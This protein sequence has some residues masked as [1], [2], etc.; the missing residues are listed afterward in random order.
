MPA[1]A[2]G[3][4]IGSRPR[5]N[6]SLLG[7]Q[8][9]ELAMEVRPTLHVV[10]S[11]VDHE[12]LGPQVDERLDQR[13]KGLLVDLLQV[14]AVAVVGEAGVDGDQRLVRLAV[15]HPRQIM[16]VDHVAEHVVSVEALAVPED[17]QHARPADLLAGV[18]AKVGRGHGGLDL[19][20]RCRRR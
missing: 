20:L 1:A 19:Q 17:Q 15:G 4:R 12:G 2:K 3:L 8:S 18:Q 14:A 10:V 16:L 9:C 7:E 11:G 5:G 6:R 13:R